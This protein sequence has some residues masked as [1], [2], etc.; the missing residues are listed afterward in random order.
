MSEKREWRGVGCLR[1]LG[2]L[3]N[4]RVAPVLGWRLLIW[5][6]ECFS[7]CFV[8]TQ[9]NQRISLIFDFSSKIQECSATKRY[10][11]PSGARF[12]PACSIGFVTS[13][14]TPLSPTTTWDTY[15]SGMLRS[16]GSASPPASSVIV[17]FT[18]TDAV[19]VSSTSRDSS[20]VYSMTSL[21]RSRFTDGRLPVTCSSI[22]CPFTTS[23][24]DTRLVIITPTFLQSCRITMFTLPV[25]SSR[26]F[27][28]P[29]SVTDCCI[30]TSSSLSVFLSKRVPIWFSIFHILPSSA[31]TGSFTVFFGAAAARFASSSAWRAAFL[32][33]SSSKSVALPTS[34]SSRFLWRI[35]DLSTFFRLLVM[36]VPFARSAKSAARSACCLAS[37]PP[38][39]FFAR[40]A[41]N[42]ADGGGGGGGAPPPALGGAGGPGAAAGGAGGAGAAAFAFASSSSFASASAFAL[43]SSSAF[44]LASASAFALAS[45]SAF[46]LASASSF[47]LASAAAL[48][49]ASAFA[50]SSAFALASASAFALSAAAASPCF[51]AASAAACAD[52][53]ASMSSPRRPPEKS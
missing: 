2:S 5:A 40:L 52:S 18:H 24:P 29:S 35:C 33:S 45:S 9:K 8:F 44:A 14:G 16:I 27:S 36:S 17:M 25:I 37:A 53:A 42:S 3:H 32:R 4:E 31:F 21:Q 43:A 50:A 47:A 34:D 6:R 23:T 7:P 10:Q 30:V 13:L 15:C 28:Q 46:A 22:F 19:V 41:M 1:M 38:P 12:H 11:V 49:A 39:A 20:V 51:A 26:K 48:A